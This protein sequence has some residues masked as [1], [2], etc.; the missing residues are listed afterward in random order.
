MKTKAKSVCHLIV[1]V[2]LF[3]ALNSNAVLAN[4]S[5]KSRLVIFA[6]S[7]LKEVFTQIAEDFKKQ[8]TQVSLVF[9]FA[10]SQELRVQIEQGAFADIV[11]TADQVHM[12]ALVEQNLVLNPVVFAHNEPVLIVDQD[13]TPTIDNL[14]DLPALKRIVL[15]A[16]V[17]PI[18]RYAEQI[19]DRAESI[20]GAGF[21]QRVMAHVISRELQVKQ[22]VAKILLKEAQAGIVYKTDALLL[23][24]EVRMIAIDSRMNVESDYPIAILK[25]TIKP[26]LAQAFVD[27]LL[28]LRAQRHL[29][30]AGFKLSIKNSKKS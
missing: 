6:A 27:E 22:V 8:H 29:A 28:S 24:K 19:L 23:P 25:R 7:S 11:A 1:C 16:S 18:G 26:Q 9:N 20:Y 13:T 12:Q 30:L 21:K 4:D 15:G 14:L 2:V 5:N 17:V 3:L 10:G